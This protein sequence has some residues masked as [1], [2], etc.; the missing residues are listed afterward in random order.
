MSH[1]LAISSLETQKLD[2]IQLTVQS[3]L[4]R[5]LVVEI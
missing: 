3:A 2:S 1:T 5:L 4:L